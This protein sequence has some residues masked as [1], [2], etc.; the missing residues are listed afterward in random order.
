MLRES[1]TSAFL[2]CPSYHMDDGVYVFI[3]WCSVVLDIKMQKKSKTATVI[4]NIVHSLACVDLK[5]GTEKKKSRTS[6]V[7]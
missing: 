1:L 2:T 3:V 5:N 4:M 6:S 7:W